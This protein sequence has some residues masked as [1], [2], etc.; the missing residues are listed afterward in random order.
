MPSPEIRQYEHDQLAEFHRE[1]W[2]ELDA[3]HAGQSAPDDDAADE[4]AGQQQLDREELAA[5]QQDDRRWVP[6]L[7]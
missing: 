7:G 3:R 5:R 6:P 4:L 1:Q 2:D